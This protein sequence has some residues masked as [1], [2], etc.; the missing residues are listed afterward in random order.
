MKKIL[1]LFGILV[2]GFV[3]YRMN[4][5]P[6]SID[7]IIDKYDTTDFS[8]FKYKYIFIRSENWTHRS[9]YLFNDTSTC[10]ICWIRTNADGNVIDR[11]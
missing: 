2:I 5:K 9:Y 7:Y 6:Y 3:I 1:L 4:K 8:Y 11:V 10:G